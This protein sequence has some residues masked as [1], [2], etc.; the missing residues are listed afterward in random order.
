MPLAN[1]EVTAS[2][3]A[4]G[5]TV[6]LAPERLLFV[7][8]KNG[9]S[10]VSGALVENIL[11]DG[12]EDTLFGAD[13]PIANAI[14]RARRRNSQTIFDAI[15]LDDNVGG[16]D[17]TGLF[18][19]TG[20]ASEDGQIIV[21]AGSKKF[22]E[23]KIAVTNGDSITVIGDAI[24]AAITADANALVT[25][26]NA[27]GVVTI[28][29][30]SAGT[31]GNTIGLRTTGTVGGT[32]VAV[33]GM[34][35]GATD[36]VLTGVLDVTGNQRY[37]GIAWQFQ[38]DLTEVVDF[39]DARFNVTNNILDGRA[40][41]S[42]TDTFANHLTALGSLNSKSLCYNADKLINDSDYVGPAVLDIPFTKIAEFAAI[43]ALRRT[44]EAVLGDLVISRS[45]RDS[46]GGAWQNSKPYFNTPFPDLLTPDVG[47]SFSDNEV[48]QLLD[49]GSWVIDANRAFST[50]IA[51]E[52]VTTYLTDA[53]AN[54]DPTFGF[55]NYVDTSTAGRE[56]IV[57]N[58]RAKY[59][60]FRA[61]GG[62]LIPGVDSANEASVAAFV[63]EMNADLADLG[64][65]SSGVGSI[66]GEQ[67]DYDKLFRENL[68]V[69]LN[70]VTG[71][72]FIS[73]KLY[74]VT[75]FRAAVYDLAI[76]FEV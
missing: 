40:F 24:A 41:V 17:A 74:I 73:A 67:V 35:A 49:A 37:Q 59:P 7:G 60:Q 46:F 27:V 71:R 22:N 55:L 69:S 26:S 2:L 52:V 30:K 42:V 14:R 62:A 10:A 3:R 11:D 33:T 44:D 72:F 63:T 20:A 6:G 23:Y 29:A 50:V 8:Q 65:V 21:Y 66:E 68:T 16:A 1:P 47:D 19:V 39:L 53:A 61:T 18:T 5:V 32:S 54:P 75:Q 45:P 15:S 31:F 9:G 70:P 58:T 38:D 34:S 56:Y 36:P 13:S 64:L 28:T 48:E 25:A 51:G 76:A 4:A 43:R 57:N 12:S